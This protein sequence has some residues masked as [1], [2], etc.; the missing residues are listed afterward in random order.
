MREVSRCSFRRGLSEAL[1]TSAATLRSEA[2]C[3]AFRTVNHDQGS[4]IHGR[5]CLDQA[6]L[7]A[8][9][10]RRDGELKSHSLSFH[11]HFDSSS[12]RCLRHD[13]FEPANVFDRY[14]IE[15]DDHIVRPESCLLRGGVARHVSRWGLTARSRY[16]TL[17]WPRRSNQHRRQASTPPSRPPLPH[18][19]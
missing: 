3:L 6:L 8:C 10:N 2:A 13:A 16:W 18:R 4:G 15:V 12:R 1:P 7:G 14:P 5:S 19:R 11:G 17:G 9:R